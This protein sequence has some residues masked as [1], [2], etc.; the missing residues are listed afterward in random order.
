MVI[1]KQFVLAISYNTIQKKNTFEQ[2]RNLY[3]K[4]NVKP[5]IWRML[6]QVLVIYGRCPI[7]TLY[8]LPCKF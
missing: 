2:L 3:V 8:V 6:L 5:A 7:D 1:C 4:H